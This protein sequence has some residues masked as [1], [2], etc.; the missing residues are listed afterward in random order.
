MIFMIGVYAWMFGWKWGVGF[1]V[2]LAT[3]IALGGFL[4][5][6][7]VESTMRTGYDKGYKMV[8]LTDC[9]ATV[10]AEEQDFAVAKN[11][12]MF[13]RPLDHQAFLAEF[14]N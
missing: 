8:T 4:T 5:N 1:V 10:S 12:P 11:F 2:L 13:S 14:A 9:T 3:D 6:C 7:C